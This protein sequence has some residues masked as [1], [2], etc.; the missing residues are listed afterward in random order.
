M[1]SSE[2]METDAAVGTEDYY[3]FLYSELLIF[4]HFLPIGNS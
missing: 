3:F 2:I 1:I 4:M